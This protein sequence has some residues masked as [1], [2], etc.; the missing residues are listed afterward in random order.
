MTILVIRFSFVLDLTGLH[1]T[2]SDEEQREELPVSVC[3]SFF[4]TPDLAQ[5]IHHTIASPSDLLKTP[6]GKII[7]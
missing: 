3:C 5:S 6:S 2:P 1:K 7:Y 4:Y